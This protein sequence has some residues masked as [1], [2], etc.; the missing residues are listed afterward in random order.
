L[1]LSSHAFVFAK[2]A[3]EKP[4]GPHD[5]TGLSA[6]LIEQADI[7]K[8]VTLHKLRHTYATRLLEGCAEL[9]DIQALLSTTQIYAHVS[10]ERMAGVMGKL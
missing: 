2:T 7:A 6:A 4:L 10:K 1:Q 9:V 5:S 8:Q 3:G